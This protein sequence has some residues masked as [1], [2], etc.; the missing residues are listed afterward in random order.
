MSDG[1][2]RDEHHVY[3][4]HDRVVPGVTRILDVLRKS[5]PVPK[6]VMENARD[7]GDIVHQA[8]ALD[9][10]NDLDDTTV[11]PEAMPY[12]KAFRKF[13][14]EVKPKI[15]STEE[16]VYN[17]MYD[18]AGCLDHRM[19]INGEEGILD[20]KT[21][22]EDPIDKVQLSAYHRAKYGP[23]RKM[24]RWILSLRPNGS[25]IITPHEDYFHIFI[26]ALTVYRFKEASKV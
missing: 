16:F 2:T 4:L 8:T 22:I 7:L 13:R 10:T 12:I 21:G 20:K 11:D 15:L 26:A 1:L 18:Y 9:A 14:F 25:Y 19:I 5:I 23:D 6:A 17:G 24:K 3:R